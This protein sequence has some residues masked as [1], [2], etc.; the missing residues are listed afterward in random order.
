MMMLAGGMISI[1]G[2]SMNTT[3]ANN[4]RNPD[5]PP[6]IT[7]ITYPK[8]F[9]PDEYVTITATVTDDEGITKVCIVWSFDK[10]KTNNSVE[11]KLDE[12][13][14]Q[15]YTYVKI[16]LK[17]EN[18]EFFIYATDTKGQKAIENNSGKNYVIQKI[19]LPTLMLYGLYGSFALIALLWAGLIFWFYKKCRRIEPY[20][21]RLFGPEI[22]TAILALCAGFFLAA[23]F[24]VIQGIAYAGRISVVSFSVM[25]SFLL[26]LLILAFSP[27]SLILLLW[28]YP[29]GAPYPLHVIAV[30]V[31]ILLYLMYRTQ[32]TAQKRLE[33]CPAYIEILILPWSERPS[34]PSWRGIATALVTL[35]AVPLALWRLRNTIIGVVQTTK[36]LSA[37]PDTVRYRTTKYFLMKELILKDEQI[38]NEFAKRNPKRAEKLRGIIEKERV[39]YGV[40]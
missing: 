23:V 18:F 24:Y 10:W 6:V 9:V 4:P 40:K 7:N 11:M 22:R 21:S 5:M 12:V 27:I 2:T 39:K 20:L 28:E 16:P 30:V 3:N 14:N 25:I 17:A 26:I 36:A 8:E 33:E 19:E 32:K 34:G 31:I 13:H 15:F 37:T 38:I 35:V 29:A 1:H